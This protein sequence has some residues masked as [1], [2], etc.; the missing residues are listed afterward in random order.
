MSLKYMND[1]WS[2]PLNSSEKIVLLALAD[3]A[4]D[5]GECWPS[6]ENLKKKTGMANSTLSKHLKILKGAGII[7]STPHGEIGSGKKVNSYKLNLM[8]EL[9]I[10][11]TL[12]LIEKI[13]HLRKTVG[14]TITPTLELRK[15]QPSNSITPTLVH[16]SF[17]EPSL[18]QQSVA[19]GAAPPSGAKKPPITNETWESYSLAYK[20]RHGVDPIRNASVNGKLSNFIKRIGI[21]EAPAVAHYFVMMSN[22][23]YESRMHDVGLLLKDAETIRA[24]WFRGK[25]QASD[26]SADDVMRQLQQ[27]TCNGFNNGNHNSG[28]PVLGISDSLGQQIQSRERPDGE[29]AHQVGA[30]VVWLRSG[31]CS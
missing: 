13:K 7:Q 15:L 16:E 27:E 17:I 22:K 1:A 24:Q 21:D 4:N 11:P 6:F 3:C 9:P 23:F 30:D 14:R 12:E 29:M 26:K 18:K 19:Q 10:T 2:M 28:F 20:N 8:S 31:G 5:D 25:E